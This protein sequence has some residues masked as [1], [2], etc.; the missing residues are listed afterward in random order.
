M[1]GKLLDVC[2]S[3]GENPVVRYQAMSTGLNS[4]QAIA[5]AFQAE[6]DRYLE[7]YP[8]FPPKEST[9]HGRSVMLILDRAT[10][11]YAPLLHELTYQALVTDLLGLEEGKFYRHTFVN[12]LGKETEDTII[13]DESDPIWNSMRHMHIAD[14][15]QE[16][17][18]QFKVAV[19]DNPAAASMLKR[20]QD[21][22]NASL[23][24]MR[25]IVASVP[26][27]Q[28]LSKKYSAHMD[29][30]GKCMEHL[31][32][33]GLDNAID[34]EQNLVTGV[35]S[36]GEP[37]KNA[38][39]DMAPLLTEATLP[40]DDKLRLL[41]IYGLSRQGDYDRKRLE[42]HA[43]LNDADKAAITNMSLFSSNKPATK[44]K[45]VQKLLNPFRRTVNPKDEDENPY[46]LSRYVPQVKKIIQDQISKAI[47]PEEFPFVKEQESAEIKNP[48]R[49]LRVNRPTWQKKSDAGPSKAQG[50]RI[51]VFIAGGL[52]YSE[53]RSVYEI[54]K[55]IKRD[56][57]IG[58]THILCPKDF[59]ASLR[60]IKAQNAPR[61]RS[62]SGSQAPVPQFGASLAPHPVRREKTMPNS[63]DTIGS[64]ASSPVSKSFGFSKF[65]KFG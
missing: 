12:G 19:S 52:T 65:L 4:P 46:A 59:L 6:M 55:V 45:E 11:L 60:E 42:A 36:D 29:I 33:L 57:L 20:R 1:A 41:M 49:S 43:N 22:Q 64:E 28:E 40:S 56:V 16:L 34:C 53:I 26:E 5:L 2:I 58:T 3:L 39:T 17:V 50:G 13:L 8:T 38:L 27:L 10:D 25:E 7:L 51:L 18:K 54:S 63:P 30:A 48:V 62:S 31:R 37:V 23:K 9:A 24:D 21:G 32:N 61:P 15:V 47:A 44:P 35:T 14:C